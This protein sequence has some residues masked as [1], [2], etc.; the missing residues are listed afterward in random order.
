MKATKED[1]DWDQQWELHAPNFQ[2]G[3]AHVSLADYGGPSCAFKLMPGPGFG[4]LSHPTT[5]IVLTLMPK[6]IMA[7][8]IDIGCGSGVLSIA[9]K[10]SGAPSVFGID[11]DDE[12][13]VHA[14]KNGA[15]NGVECTFGKTL[16]MVP[17]DPLILMNMISSE[18]KVA[19]S[20]FPLF[21]G[22]M[23][24]SGY[25]KEEKDPDHYGVIIEKLELEGWK[26]FKI[27]S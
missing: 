14:R 20:T 26:G 25:P 8:V 17:K 19:W 10:L 2:K 21:K 3:F 22:T 1:I 11:I 16:P 12:A 27:Q 18:Q 15:L 4:D 13:I 23:I 9:A 7:P 6:K 24:V 5:R